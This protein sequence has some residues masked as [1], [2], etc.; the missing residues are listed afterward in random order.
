VTF[1]AFGVLNFLPGGTADAILGPSAT[2]QAIAILNKQLGLNQP[3]LVRYGKWLWEAVHGQLGTSLVSH[4]TVASMIA[5]RAPVSAELGVMAIIE[6][7]C[8][9]VPIAIL[10][11]RRPN[12]LLDKT[13]TFISLMGISVPGFGIALLLILVFALK[14]QLVETA[15]FVSIS[16]GLIPNLKSLLLPSISLSVF[17]FAIY[18]RVLRGDMV[19]QLNTEHYVETARGKGMGE[20]RMLV[21][22]VLP[23]S[24]FGFVTVLTVNLGLLIGGAVVAEEIFAVP[25]MGNA[26]ITAINERDA[27]VVQGVVVCLALTVVAA[28]L[29]ADIL[30]S[31]LDPRVRVRHGR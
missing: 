19:N 28:N 29:L 20:T 16:Q 25:G 5:T 26:L 30:Y 23:N 4:Q 8:L 3:I 13:T 2:P 10:C 17:L 12:G 15:G 11:A 7:V 22:H 27:P 6:A 1:V 31:V 14:L 9:A 18:L 21:K 24:L